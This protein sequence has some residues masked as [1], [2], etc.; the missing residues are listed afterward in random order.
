[1]ARLGQAS[2][3]VRRPP[4]SLQHQL[5]VLADQRLRKNIAA[6]RA[7]SFGERPEQL[8][9]GDL[10]L[11]EGDR[12][13]NPIQRQRRDLGLGRGT[14]GDADRRIAQNIIVDQQIDRL[15]AVPAGQRRQREVLEPDSRV[16]QLR[17]VS[18]QQDRTV[19]ACRRGHVAIGTRVLPS[20]LQQ[21]APSFRTKLRQRKA[22]DIVSRVPSVAPVLLQQL[23]DLFRRRLQQHLAMPAW[24]PDRF[25]GEMHWHGRNCYQIPRSTSTRQAFFEK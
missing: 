24:R 4:A 11:L 20:V 14:A 13:D 15:P 22:L 6:G 7:H 2:A 16:K 17:L 25:V 10:A 12:L 9:V 1:M 21:A 8:G 5:P 3:Q 18:G 19:F 23:A